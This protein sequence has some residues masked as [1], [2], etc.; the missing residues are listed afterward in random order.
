MQI[1]KQSASARQGQGGWGGDTWGGGWGGGLP[2]GKPADDKPKDRALVYV[3]NFPAGLD[4]ASIKDMLGG[5]QVVSVKVVS[6]DT[7]TYTSALVRFASEEEAT[8][9]IKSVN[10]QVPEGWEKPIQAS[11]AADKEA[12]MK[13]GK[14]KK[15]KEGKGGF[16]YEPYGGG[17]SWGSSWGGDGWGKG[18]KGKIEV[19]MEDLVQMIISTGALPGGTGKPGGMPDTV[20]QVFIAGL[21]GDC[22]DLHLYHLW[23]ALARSLPEA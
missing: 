15:G 16:G 9:V 11:F 3:T 4:E 7:A 12:H 14:G 19:T 8:E 22:T 1:R 6:N 10:G 2:A 20:T 23:H 5:D 13:G 21:P 18:G 17:G